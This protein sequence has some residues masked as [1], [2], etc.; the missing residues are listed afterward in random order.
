[1]NAHQRWRERYVAFYT[2]YYQELLAELVFARWERIDLLIGLL[3][4]ATASGSTLAGLALWNTAPGKWLWTTLSVTAAVAAI[5]KAAARVGEHLKKQSEN[6]RDF[7]LLRYNLQFILYRMT[8]DDDS[9]AL[10]S[11]FLSLNGKLN[12]L[13]S[14]SDPDIAATVSLRNRAQKS[15]DA[16]L[17]KL[18]ITQTGLQEHQGDAKH[19]NPTVATSTPASNPGSSTKADPQA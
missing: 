18:G 12:E 13:K 6:R 9:D 10:E 3:V 11:D 19:E 5:F 1:M 8:S 4:A 15:L 2:A 14:K 17:A 16:E 7:A